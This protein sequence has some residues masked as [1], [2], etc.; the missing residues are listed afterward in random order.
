M[1]LYI[2]S[3]KDSTKKLLEVINKFS[4]VAG[5]KINTQKLVVFLNTNNEVAER[6]IKKK[7]QNTIY[8]CTKKNKIPRN[9]L[10]EVKNLYSVYYKALTKEIEDDTN[11]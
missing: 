2:E 4:E 5:Y 1:V 8:N 3:P 11:K 6:E 10:K 7:K 9:K